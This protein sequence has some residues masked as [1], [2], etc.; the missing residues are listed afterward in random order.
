MNG[1]GGA[2]AATRWK[3]CG[4]FRNENAVSCDTQVAASAI[5]FA[6]SR[7]VD[8]L[9]MVEN[10]ESCLERSMV[11]HS[12]S[13]LTYGWSGAANLWS[14][15]SYV[16]PAERPAYLDPGASHCGN[17]LAQDAKIQ[18]LATTVALD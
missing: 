11:G 4:A 12:S 6:V 2:A 13:L 17:D 9:V 10:L 14:P 15:E 8:E 18:L 1:F 16:A 3:R 7:K 5:S